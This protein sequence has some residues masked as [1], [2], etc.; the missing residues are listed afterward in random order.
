[1]DGTA[2]LVRYTL[3]IPFVRFHGG[4]NASNVG[5]S[6]TP[7]VPDIPDYSISQRSAEVWHAGV[8]QRLVS[9]EI[10]QYG[11]MSVLQISGTAI[12]G[13]PSNELKCGLSLTL[14]GIIGVVVV[15]FAIPFSPLK[16]LG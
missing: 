11:I 2:L 6:L 10:T 14:L 9:S 8:H 4:N 3:G 1:M 13:D 5:P 12:R 7:L 15:G 16:L